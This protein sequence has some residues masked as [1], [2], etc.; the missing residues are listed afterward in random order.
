M[1]FPNI[2]CVTCLIYIQHPTCRSTTKATTTM[3]ITTQNQ[4]SSCSNTDERNEHLATTKKRKLLND[5]PMHIA[6][7]AARITASQIT[8]SVRERLESSALPQTTV[9]EAMREETYWRSEKLRH[10]F[11]STVSNLTLNISMTSCQNGFTTL[12]TMDVTH[13]TTEKEFIVNIVK[14]LRK[15]GQ[16]SSIPP[17]KGTTV[18][19]AGRDWH[20][21]EGLERVA[22]CSETGGIGMRGKRPLPYFCRYLNMDEKIRLSDLD[23]HQT[24]CVNM[25]IA[26]DA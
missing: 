20:I 12:L 3:S 25:L 2:I 7:K 9:V 1:K 15:K 24:L 18:Y 22:M 13:S 19:H 21:E 8:A 4:P 17:R 10:L 26:D 5:P 14:L 11:I 23:C 6:T 16:L